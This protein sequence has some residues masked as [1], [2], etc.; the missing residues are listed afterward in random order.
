MD[1][2]AELKRLHKETKTEAGVY[3]IA[4]TV[5]QKVFVGSTMNLKTLNGKRFQLKMGSHL[6][7]QLQEEW[8][9]YGEDAFRIEV[10]EILKT[11]ETGYFD[12]QHELEKLEQK[13]IEKLQPFVERGYH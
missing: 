5:N 9:A 3:Q 2:K 6:N 1:R 7:K 13:W 8:N 11:K 10:V 4:N 12:A